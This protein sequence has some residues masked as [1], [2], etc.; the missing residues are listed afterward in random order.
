MFF[1][2]DSKDSLTHDEF[3]KMVQSLGAALSARP[4]CRH[5]RG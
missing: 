3:T 5:C 4:R 1:D 2:K